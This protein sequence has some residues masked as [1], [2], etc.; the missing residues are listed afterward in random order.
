MHKFQYTY[1]SDSLGHGLKDQIPSLAFESHVRLVVGARHKDRERI[2][3]DTEVFL[4]VSG[5]YGVCH[6]VEVALGV[7][8]SYG[9]YQCGIE[10]ILG[11]VGCHLS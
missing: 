4:E 1:S 11:L 10:V 9:V 6:D 7:S 2:S 5:S 8:G 3:N